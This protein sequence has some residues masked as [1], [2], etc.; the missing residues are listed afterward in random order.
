MVGL[1]GFLVNCAIVIGITEMLH[2]TR[3]RVAELNAAAKIHEHLATIVASS[4]DAILGENFDEVVTSW[5]EGATRL[6][7][8]G[9]EEM[10]GRSIARIIPP[11]R[12]EK[13]ADI[14]AR[15]K[16]GK[17]VENYETTLIAKEGGEID[18]SMTRSPLKN[19]AGDVVGIST[20][21][22]DFGDRRRMED[23]LRRVAEKCHRP[24]SGAR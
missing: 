20:I 13:E 4:S 9:A 18:V 1:I 17:S 8:Y 16:A 19:A 2:L 23:A 14:V 15:I 5:N 24:K 11:E 10:V 6:L 3:T 7:G 22:R 12:L 21:F